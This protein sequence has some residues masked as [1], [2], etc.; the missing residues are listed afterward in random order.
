MAID[1]AAL[2]AECLTDPTGLGLPALVATADGGTSTGGTRAADVAAALNLVRASIQV[3]RSDIAPSEICNAIN[4][5][6]YT[7]L[8]GTPTAAQLSTER[9]YLAWLTGLMSVPTVRLQ[10]DDG[11]D[12]PAV[13]NLKAMFAGGT[14]T[15]TRLQA[16]QTRTG[17]RVEQLFGAGAVVSWQ[18]VAHALTG[19]A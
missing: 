7:A 13:T 2:K 17:S 6:D 4:V 5:A 3:K 1:Y 10:N 18:D 12:A 9:R 16:L 11:T 15:L 8:P 19:A 14:G